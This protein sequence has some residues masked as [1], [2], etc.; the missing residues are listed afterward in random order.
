MS[1]ATRSKRDDSA[2]ALATLGS[3]S[4]SALPPSKNERATR[5]RRSLSP[6]ASDGVLP[7]GVEITQDAAE[8]VGDQRDEQRRHEGADEAVEVGVLQ[9]PAIPSPKFTTPKIYAAVYAPTSA[10]TPR[11]VRKNAGMSSDVNANW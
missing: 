8:V 2:I 5:N 11:N 10:S 9:P 3:D 7:G 6:S 4:S 1:S